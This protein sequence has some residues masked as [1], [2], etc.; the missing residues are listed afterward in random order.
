MQG[1]YTID[2]LSAVSFTKGLGCGCLDMG[3]SSA[4]YLD[5]DEKRKKVLNKIQKAYAEEYGVPSVE[6]FFAQCVR[7]NFYMQ[8][9]L[10]NV[11]GKECALTFGYIK[12]G[13]TDYFKQDNSF[14]KEKLT[15]KVSGVV[16][17]HAWLTLPSMEILDLTICTTRLVALLKDKN[18]TPHDYQQQLMASD[19]FGGVVVGDGNNLTGTSLIYYPQVVGF[20]YAFKSGFVQVA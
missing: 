17:I 14:Y 7:T 6:D 15:S 13:E 4:Y 16:N 11:I 18:L 9:I 1:R 12:D 20:D 19:D 8:P 10:S 5:T 3:V 2:Y